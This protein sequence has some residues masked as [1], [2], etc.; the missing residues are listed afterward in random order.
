MDVCLD[1]FAKIF[2]RSAFLN[3]YGGLSVSNTKNAKVME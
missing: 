2:K 1:D 3:N